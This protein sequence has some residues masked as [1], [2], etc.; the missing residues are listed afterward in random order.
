MVLEIPMR[1]RTVL[2]NPFRDALYTP[3]ELLGGYDPATP[4]SFEQTL[5]FRVYRHFVEAGRLSKASYTETI[6]QSLHDNSIT[7]ALNTFR[8]GKRLAAV[9]GGHE[10]ERA[11]PAYASVVCMA[12]ALAEAGY[13]VT[14]GG[15][16][17]AM[18]ASH[19]GAFYAGASTDEVGAALAKLKTASKLPGQFAKLVD[20]AGNV[21][22][23]L[24]Q[25]LHAWQR[26]AFEVFSGRKPSADSLAVPTWHYGH[27]PPTPFATQIAKYFQNSIRE[28]GLI[29]IALYGIIFV[30]G[31]AGTLQEVFQDAAQNFYKSHDWFSPMVFLSNCQ[32]LW[33]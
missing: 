18:E 13:I 22:Y 33:T 1:R 14:S 29:A 9:M 15:G 24:L 2:V 31:S 5:D 26:P 23:T 30:E 17:G 20:D 11:A 28:D 7:D 27:E 3:A 4:R 16:P 25:A 21:D 19:L 8:E 32:M 12:K 6:V 10:L